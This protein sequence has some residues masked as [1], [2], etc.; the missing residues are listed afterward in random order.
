MKNI[1]RKDSGQAT[2]RGFTLIELIVA[3]GLFASVMTIAAG[4]YLTII[5][6]NQQA[7]AIATG[8]DNV[9]FALESMTRNIRSGSDYG[10][11]ITSG[12]DCPYP[13]GDTS[14]TF[15]D[16]YADSTT[17]SLGSGVIQ[18]TINGGSAINL[19]DPSVNITSLK[20]YVS[21]T[22]SYSAS[23]DILQPYVTIAI[24]GTVPAGP[25]Q[26]RSFTVESSA[27]W[28]GSNI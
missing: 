19:T 24:S 4:A 22:R 27:A 28:R 26:T 18:E 2:T 12:T 16:V 20:F 8:I 11:G 6:L 23:G 17:Y 21:G 14:F 9:S 5:R 3:V 25:G 15:K 1:P 10:C 7:Q 13:S